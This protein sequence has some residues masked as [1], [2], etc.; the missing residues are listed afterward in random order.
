MDRCE[1]QVSSFFLVCGQWV[2]S[3]FSL[4]GIY[5]SGSLATQQSCCCPWNDHDLKKKEPLKKTAPVA[6]GRAPGGETLPPAAS[7]QQL[8]RRTLFQSPARIARTFQVPSL[9]PAVTRTPVLKAQWAQPVTLGRTMSVLYFGPWTPSHLA[10]KCL[11]AIP[12]LLLS[13]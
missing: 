9:H 1:N 7:L 11:T 10:S 6:G 3:P 5:F 12:S 13:T 2:R 4:D 8:R